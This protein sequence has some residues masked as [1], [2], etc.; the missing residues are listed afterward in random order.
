M[1]FFY[2]TDEEEL[3]LLLD[4]STLP[5]TGEKMQTETDEQIDEP[6]TVEGTT[7]DEVMGIK[8]SQS[9]EPTA[10][11]TASAREQSRIAQANALQPTNS[12]P[13]GALAAS[14]LPSG[15][16]CFLPSGESKTINDQKKLHLQ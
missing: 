1:T 5:E 2:P 12:E 9:L 11:D 8:N 15:A 6:L 10:K 14:S 13:G 3:V 16:A 7:T 4:N